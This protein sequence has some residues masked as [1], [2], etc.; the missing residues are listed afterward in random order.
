MLIIGKN[1][2]KAWAFRTLN[3]LQRKKIDDYKRIYS[4][5]PLHLRIDYANGYIEEKN[6]NKCLIFDSVD[7]NNKLLKNTIITGI[8]LEIRSKK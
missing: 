8:E 3:I 7:V 1:H 2:R 4:V 6:G 5:N